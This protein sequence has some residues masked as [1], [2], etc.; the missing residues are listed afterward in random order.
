MSSKSEKLAN[1]TIEELVADAAR[2]LKHGVV[3]TIYE[4]FDAFLSAL[5]ENPV[6]TNLLES[7]CAVLVND[8]SKPLY[9]EQIKP[10]AMRRLGDGWQMQ[11]FH[12]VPGLLSDLAPLMT[13]KLDVRITEF[14]ASMDAMARKAHSAVIPRLMALTSHATQWTVLCKI[15]R[16][17]TEFTGDE[18]AIFVPPHFDRSVF[19]VML[20][21]RL[22]FSGESRH[23]CLGT[24]DPSFD[25][26]TVAASWDIE[27]CHIPDQSEYPVVLAG[28]HAH[29]SFGL[30]PRAHSVLC[31][32]PS[33]ASY[34]YSLLFFVVPRR[35]FDTPYAHLPLK[36]A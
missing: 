30:P 6:D 12:A 23:L 4:E 25:I 29:E 26:D 7:A 21:S 3:P 11:G 5:D 9:N 13:V 17:R 34:R 16:Y 19:S 1:A 33:Q 31:M 15:W 10:S 14:Y 22:D 32:D 36:Y 18:G 2:E 24:A 20:D 35:G 28:I 8:A 27:N